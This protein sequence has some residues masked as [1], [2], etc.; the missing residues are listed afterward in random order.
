MASRAC[1]NCSQEGHISKE[2]DRPRDMPTVTCRNCDQ[3]GHFSKECPLPRDLWP[4]PKPR[5]TDTMGRLHSKVFN[6]HYAK[7]SRQAAPRSDAMPLRLRRPMAS[8]MEMADEDLMMGPPL[9]RPLAATTMA[10]CGHTKVRRKVPPVE[11]ADGFGD[12]DSGWGLMIWPPLLRLLV[13][14][15]TLVGTA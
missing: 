3:Q 12:G 6:K 15:T 1:R 7:L 13:V 8:V 11:E 14:T 9:L 2:C 10:E 5:R 4:P